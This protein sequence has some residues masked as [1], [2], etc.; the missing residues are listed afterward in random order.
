MHVLF[1]YDI[2][3]VDLECL[4]SPFILND[5]ADNPNL[6]PVF[7]FGR[8]SVSDDGLN[9]ALDSNPMVR[10][11]S[12]LIP[13]T[14]SASVLAFDFDPRSGFN[15]DSATSHSCNLNEAGTNA[16]G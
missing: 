16:I 11:P 9:D 1:L 6:I 12:T 13:N 15:F 5:P 2:S 7:D 3:S 14:I 8:C 10:S 4:P